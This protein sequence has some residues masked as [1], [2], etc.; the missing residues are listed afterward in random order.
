VAV[1]DPGSVIAKSLI[2]CLCGLAL[3]VPA[4][5]Q[6]RSRFVRATP[7]QPLR[8]PAPRAEQA[9]L[10]SIA[11]SRLPIAEQDNMALAVGLFSV[12]GH[13]VRERGSRGREPLI[14]TGGRQNRVAA[15]GFSWRF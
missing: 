11:V 15:V 10:E 5:A 4:A 14:D 3:A 9:S 2:T 6:Q 12:G 13:F 8:L 1:S 7:A